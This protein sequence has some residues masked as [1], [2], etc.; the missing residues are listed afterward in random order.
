MQYYKKDLDHKNC[1][2][3]K[4]LSAKQTEL[5][6]STSLEKVLVI[7]PRRDALEGLEG[8]EI[9]SAHKVMTDS[10]KDGQIVYCYLW[11]VEQALKP[12]SKKSI[13]LV[14]SIWVRLV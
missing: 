7:T 13:I 3:D 8:D 6:E 14:S 2:A 5:E 4:V 10:W 12:A 1:L 11:M 9:L